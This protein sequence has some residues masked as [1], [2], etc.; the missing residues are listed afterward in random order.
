[1]KQY[2]IISAQL[3]D[4]TRQIIEAA[5]ETAYH[6]ADLTL[7]R[8]N[9]LLGQRIV[10]EELGGSERADYGT[11][12]ING[13]SRELTSI[14]G[15]GFTRTNLYTFVQFY[16]AFPEIFHTVSGQSSDSVKQIV[17]TACGQ[18][19]NPNTSEVET[20][21]MKNY[22]SEYTE[23]LSWSHYRTL[24]QVSDKEAR[25][26]YAEEAAREG[27]SVRTLQRNISSQYY[28]RML[29]T[30]DKDAVHQ[31]MTQLTAP[32]QDK[33][34]YIK[35]PV[36]AEFLGLGQRADFLES[37][38]EDAILTHLQQFLLEMGKGY[39]F[40]ARQQHIH[41][42]KRDY[43]I[44]LVFYNINLKCYVLVDLKTT[45]V[46]HQDVGQ[47]DM[48]VRMYDELKRTEG[49]NPTIG[50]LLCADTDD[51]IARFSVLKGN[52]QLFAS[53]YLTYMPT[54]EQLR[55]EIERQKM[56]YLLQKKENEANS[57]IK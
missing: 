54:K 41:T 27:W 30:Y 33:L 32:L 4:D 56:F 18:F 9:W 1:M 35:S 42:E 19:K 48:Y 52:E 6:L 7:V 34:E 49:D 8:R 20:I 13:L 29:Q 51:D 55:E 12:I 25:D 45:T 3:L 14:Y 53:K 37:T 15:K 57:N 17:H 21:R 22:F 28:H 44:D 24:L 40:V 43:Y 39:A 11:Y 23:K 36:I 16:K 46:T 2:N 38:L 26:W 10:Q 50:I 47:M 31:E 5:Q